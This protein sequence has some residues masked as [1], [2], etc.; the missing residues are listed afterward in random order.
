MGILS[1]ESFR[2]SFSKVAK[3]VVC[4]F[5]IIGLIVIISSAGYSL[6]ANTPF[7][8]GMLLTRENNSKALQLFQVGWAADPFPLNSYSY[9]HR[10][11]LYRDVPLVSV[12]CRRL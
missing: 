12:A 11:Q 5:K 6:Q 9:H 3:R 2:Q 10:L 1:C 7:F 8:D 4:S